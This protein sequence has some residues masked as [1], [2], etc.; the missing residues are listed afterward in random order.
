MGVQ[1]FFFFTIINA[2]ASNYATLTSCSSSMQ[3]STLQPH[4]LQSLFKPSQYRPFVTDHP[5]G[6]IFLNPDPSNYFGVRITSNQTLHVKDESSMTRF[7]FNNIGTYTKYKNSGVA[8]AFNMTTDLK[9]PP[10]SHQPPSRPN[11]A[12][13][14]SEAA[15]AAVHG[16]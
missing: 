10:K 16:A 13:E 15:P 1:V 6:E 7:T 5:Q 4:Y 2:M 3:S 9:R 11:Y 8:T 14:A 12:R